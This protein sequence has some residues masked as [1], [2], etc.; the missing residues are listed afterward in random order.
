MYEE[1][2]RIGVEQKMQITMP[3]WASKTQMAHV[4]SRPSDITLTKILPF[5]KFY[6][7]RQNEIFE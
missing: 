7:S 1:N 4:S 5:R 2:W 6:T 3:Q